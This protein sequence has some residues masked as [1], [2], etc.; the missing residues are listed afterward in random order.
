[1]VSGLSC[2]KCFKLAIGVCLGFL[3]KILNIFII[4]NK[5]GGSHWY[6]YDKNNIYRCNKEAYIKHWL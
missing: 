2:W 1:M 3:E 6:N 5:S 4:F